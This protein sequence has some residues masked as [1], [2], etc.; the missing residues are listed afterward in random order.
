MK[1]LL[2]LGLTM[3][4]LL[5]VVVAAQAS[6]SPSISNFTAVTSTA[7]QSGSITDSE[8]PLAGLALQII[9]VNSPLD[10]P[11]QQELQKMSDFLGT[12]NYTIMDYFNADVNP[13]WN[14]QLNG[15]LFDDIKKLLPVG[16]DLS[17]VQMHEFV[18][19]TVENY[20][21]I[22][23]DVWVAMEFATQ[24]RP[25]QDTVGI[26]SYEDGSGEFIWAALESKVE[27]EEDKAVFK[28]DF[29]Q[30][31]LEKLNDRAFMFGVLSTP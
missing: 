14:A 3:M 17:S 26:L 15:H 20:N 6:E 18:T 21:E 10:L 4:L 30:N 27:T 19:M 9:G 1:K 23:G 8:V 28:A 22:V 11:R 31:L 2:S 7:R 16:T 29:T 24:Y 12:G 13:K 25:G 5:G